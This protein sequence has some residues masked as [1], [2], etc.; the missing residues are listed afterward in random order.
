M[1][2]SQNIIQKNSSITDALKALS[3]VE[4]KCLL[5]IDKR[6]VVIG[7]LTDG[8]VRRN[9]IKSKDLNIKVG[10]ICN[11]KF[12]F[13]N[14]NTS[15]IKIH[16]IFFKTKTPLIPVVSNKKLLNIIFINEI[17]NN[18]NTD[19]PV[20]V[21]KN[22]DIIIMA[23]GKGQRL[24]PFS[25]LLPKPLIP[26]NGKPA[27]DHLIDKFLNIGV[28]KIYIT[29]NYKKNIIKSY[30]KDQFKNRKIIYLE[31]KKPLGTASSLSLIKADKKKS[32]LV[33]NCD[34]F[35]NIQYDEF[36]DY[37]VSQKNDFTIVAAFK[38]IVVPYGVCQIDKNQKLKKI[39]EKPSLN[40]LVV[41][42]AYCFNNKLIKHIPKNKKFDMNDFIKKLIQK[43]Y[44]VGIY[45]ISEIDWQDVG[46]WPE[47]FK[48]ISNFQK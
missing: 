43:K 40:N 48:T 6:N 1:N 34:T 7:T 37:H 10:N 13:F 16:E 23:G 19:N 26:I 30:I 31:E 44:K 2:K 47:Y 4:N 24:N 5:V 11:R 20:K 45:P 12:L 38:K 15:K 22:V 27:I 3:R 29:V 9:L 8:D 14:K 33:I 32:S 41:V 42:G 25:E 35:L 46:E 28:N 21:F 36:F 17:L 39:I 18:K